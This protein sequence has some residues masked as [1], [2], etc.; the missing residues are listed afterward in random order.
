MEAELIKIKVKQ[1]LNKLDSGDYDNLHCWD[2]AEAI[3]KAQLIWCRKQLHGGNIY[4]EG[5]EQS[6]MR[7]DDLQILLN[8]INIDE[9]YDS[10]TFV[11]I[12][13]PEN[14][15]AFKRVSPFISKGECENASCKCYFIEEANVDFYLKNSL[16][17]PSFDWRETFHTLKNNR[18]VIYTNNEFKVDNVNLTYYR[19]PQR[20]IFKD[21]EDYLGNTNT[22]QTLEFKDDIV[23]LIINE[24]VN[25]LSANIEQYN[26]YKATDKQNNESN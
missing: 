9:V 26:S 16:K 4:R 14:Y 22:E 7:V 15:F 3:N 23:E 21:C 13:L 17:K 1:Q 8:T 25:I 19:L 10:N 11:E 20:I 12:N 2:I 5:D 18:V 24:T 6:T